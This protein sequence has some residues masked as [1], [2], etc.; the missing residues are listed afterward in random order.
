[1]ETFGLSGANFD[2]S[3]GEESVIKKRNTKNRRRWQT[4]KSKIEIKIER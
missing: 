1:M 2:E 4:E 3:M